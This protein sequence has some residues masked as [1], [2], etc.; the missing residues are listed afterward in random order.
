M[1]GTENHIISCSLLL[2]GLLNNECSER[3]NV[4]FFSA[5]ANSR[6]GTYII[7]DTNNMDNCML[8]DSPRSCGRTNGSWANNRTRNKQTV[9]QTQKAEHK[10]GWHQ[11]KDC[12]LHQQI[13]SSLKPLEVINTLRFNS[14]QTFVYVCT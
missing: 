10:R 9:E 5:H 4:I 11:R 7:R 8:T 12:V 13:N 6:Y 14:Q 2:N 1:D 3:L